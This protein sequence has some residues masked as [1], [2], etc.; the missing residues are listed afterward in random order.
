MH[1]HK[2]KEL[3][4]LNIDKIKG[5][6][7]LLKDENNIRNNLSLLYAQISKDNLFNGFLNIILYK[8][9]N[10]EYDYSND[11]KDYLFKSYFDDD[12]INYYSE[13]LKEINQGNPIYFKALNLI[14]KQYKKKKSRFKFMKEYL[15]YNG[16]RKYNK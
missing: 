3:P 10:L 12:F 15:F 6:P 2:V 16:Q 8:I 14:E 4:K 7:E 5:F 1:I 9:F 11:V 13:L